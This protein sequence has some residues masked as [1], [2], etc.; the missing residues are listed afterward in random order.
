M[1]DIYSMPN[2]AVYVLHTG[3]KILG[4]GANVPF[5]CVIADEDQFLYKDYRYTYHKSIN[6]WHVEA[7]LKTQQ[8]YCEILEEIAGRPV[9]SMNE[10]FKDC[11]V[12]VESPKI[13]SAVNDMRG[14][15]SGCCALKKAEIGHNVLDISRCFEKCSLLETA[16]EIPL[17]VRS[18]NSAFAFCSNLYQTPD[19]SE[20]I[21]IIF[22]DNAFEGC[23]GLTKGPDIYKCM[24]LKSMKETF[25]GCINMEHAS[26]LPRTV[27]NA[28]GTFQDCTSLKERPSIPMS[29]QVD[30]NTFLGCIV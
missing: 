25:K 21:E 13:P 26:A 19:L 1:T 22:M 10:T 24:Y 12:L 7:M 6:G 11:T 27:E 28:C 8:Y 20:H 17:G 16:P 2:F 4:D 23:I 5:P 15:F 30:E 9:L 18:I 29:A 3:E 14:T